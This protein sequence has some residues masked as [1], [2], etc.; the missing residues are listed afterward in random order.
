MSTPPLGIGINSN[1]ASRS[2][3][4][5]RELCATMGKIYGGGKERRDLEG[6][7]SPD[8][9]RRRRARRS[10]NTALTRFAPHRSSRNGTAGI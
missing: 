2:V 10:Q 9:E 8:K 1:A 7:V 6:G 5:Q 4:L 3:K